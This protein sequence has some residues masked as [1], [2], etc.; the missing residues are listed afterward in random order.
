MQ[1]WVFPFHLSWSS[2]GR[3]CLS[4]ENVGTYYRSHQQQ[5]RNLEGMFTISWRTSYSYKIRIMQ[6]VHNMSLFPTPKGVIGKITKSK[7]V[8]LEW[9][10]GRRAFPLVAWHTLEL[11]KALNG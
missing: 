1:S 8:F 6:Y 5:I 2:S 11:P 3:K 10:S 4:C 9:Q 7:D